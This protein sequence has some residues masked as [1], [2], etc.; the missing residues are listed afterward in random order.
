MVLLAFAQIVQTFFHVVEFRPALVDLIFTGVEF[1]QKFRQPIFD[2]VIH[3]IRHAC[4]VNILDRIY[5][6]SN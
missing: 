4:L 5:P 3:T 1:R 2:L 6:T